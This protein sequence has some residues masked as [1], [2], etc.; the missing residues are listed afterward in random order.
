MQATAVITCPMR[1]SGRKL[2]RQEKINACLNCSLPECAEDIEFQLASVIY[3]VESGT[4]KPIKRTVRKLAKALGV[5]PQE[6]QW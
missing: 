4:H 3:S 6:I 2:T 5:E 1:K